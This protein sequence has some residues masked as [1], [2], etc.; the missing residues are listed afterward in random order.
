VID[1]VTDGITLGI[2][3]GEA[4]GVVLGINDGVDVGIALGEADGVVVGVAVGATDGVTLGASE[5]VAEGVTEGDIDG[6]SVRTVGELDGFIEGESENSSEG[7]SEGASVGRLVGASVGRLV[8][9]LEGHR[10]Q[11]SLHVSL[12]EP[13]L[14]LARSAPPPMLQFKFVR[15]PISNFILESAHL[16]SSHSPQAKGQCVATSP[17]H[18]APGFCPAKLQLLG[19]PLFTS[20]S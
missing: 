7:I 5:G 2:N 17:T 4:E 8:G 16:F 9:G 13:T 20:P 15:P 19:V 1:G 6:V 14:Q 18:L 12:I 3:D 11:P 10:P